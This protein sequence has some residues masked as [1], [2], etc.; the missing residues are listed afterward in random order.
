M[1]TVII[2]DREVFHDDSQT[3]EVLKG[4]TFQIEHSL[5]SIAKWESKW[6]KPFLT[7]DNKTREQTIDYIRCMTVT[8]NVKPE[9]YLFMPAKIF[10]DIADYIKKPMTATWFN[11]RPGIKKS[12]EIITAEILYYCMIAYNIPMEFQKWHLNRLLTL[13]R[14]C[15]IKGQKPDKMSRADAFAQQ[16]VI[17]N[18]RRQKHNTKG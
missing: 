15:S 17:N 18:A 2:P 1:F 9:S 11:E 3:F 8:Q 7:S 12:S 6:E 4:E 5:V 10:D 16:R 14:V 13:I